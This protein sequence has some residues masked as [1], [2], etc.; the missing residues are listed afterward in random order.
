MPS[1]NDIDRANSAWRFTGRDRWN[2]YKSV[3]G[4]R[5]DRFQWEAVNFDTGE[6]AWVD[7]PRKMSSEYEERVVKE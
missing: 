1:Y 4:W 3:P 7:I 5:L 2:P 6:V